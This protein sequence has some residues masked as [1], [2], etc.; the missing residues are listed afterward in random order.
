MAC[1]VR[2]E[3]VGATGRSAPPMRVGRNPTLVHGTVLRLHGSTPS[4]D[5]FRG[6][7]V[8]R[9]RPPSNWLRTLRDRSEAAIDP[10]LI[11]DVGKGQ[12]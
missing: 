1:P 12:L 4:W 9:P 10:R 5:L 7:S 2:G 3:G 11:A 8:L 6:V